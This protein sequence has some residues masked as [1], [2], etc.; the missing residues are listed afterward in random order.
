MW[1]IPIPV[2][3]G[4]FWACRRRHKSQTQTLARLMSCQALHRHRH[5]SW[6]LTCSNICS[7]SRDALDAKNSKHGQ[8]KANNYGSLK[9]RP[10]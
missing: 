6:L 9:R 2:P 7:G 1:A 4:I 10:K 3:F 8:H 5:R